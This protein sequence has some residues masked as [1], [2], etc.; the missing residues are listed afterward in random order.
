MHKKDEMEL[1]ISNKSIRI[2][3]VFTII[4]LF[5]VGFSEHFGWL[6]GANWYVTIGALS[7]GLYQFLDRYYFS[8]V[9]DKKNFFKFIG[10]VILFTFIMIWTLMWVAR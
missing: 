7:V 2:T 5:V 4:A 3:W 6:H 8:K 10:L 1:E 9:T